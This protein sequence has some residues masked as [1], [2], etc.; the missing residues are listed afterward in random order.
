MQVV[1]YQLLDREGE[2]I[3]PVGEIGLWGDPLQEADAMG[4]EEQDKGR[5]EE[6]AG[7]VQDTEADTNYKG[8]EDRDQPIA[9]E[10]DLIFIQVGEDAEKEMGPQ[11]EPW[12]QQVT[13][14]AIV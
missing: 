4:C 13:D 11:G 9:P 8:E 2:H 5:D 10:H 14:R 12:G 6:E 3:D 1:G 7:R